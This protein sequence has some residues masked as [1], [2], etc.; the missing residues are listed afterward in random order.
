MFPEERLGG[1]L[2]FRWIPEKPDHGK[3]F[4]TLRYEITQDITVGLDYRPLTDDISFAANWR[5]ISEQGNWQPAIILGT[6]NDD[7]EDIAS[8]SY[9]VTASKFL[10]DLAGFQFSPYGGATFIEE[11]DD[12][13]PVAGL[14]VR[15][16]IWSAM[17]SYSGTTEHITISR[18]IGR[19]TASIFLWGM[20]KPGIAWTWRF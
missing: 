10:G 20:E 1:I 19:H 17:Y 2:N 6:S 16:G 14:H 11:L 4:T 5:A 3:I 15:K 18:Q 9:Y 12:L 8:Q 13:K 7:F